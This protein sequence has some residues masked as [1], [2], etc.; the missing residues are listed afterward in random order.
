M[1][2]FIPGLF[3][4]PIH[5]LFGTYFVDQFRYLESKGKNY[6]TLPIHSEKTVKENA[7]F[8]K[9]F[10]K[11]KK[12]LTF[13]THSKG[14]I[15]LLDTLIHFPELRKNIKRIFFIQA[16][17]FGTPLVHLIEEKLALK[18]FT[19]STIYALRGSWK[20]LNEISP[21]YRIQYMNIHQDKIK[22]IVNTMDITCVGSMVDL[23][24][25]KIK[26]VLSPFIQY[27]DKVGAKG[28]GIVPFKS[29]QLPGA[30]NIQVN[31]I[32][33]STMVVK[34]TLQDFDRMEFTSYLFNENLEKETYEYQYQ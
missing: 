11:D 25:K 24:E 32:D 9:D 8:I 22:E 5:Y 30:K 1:V 31:G 26:S 19:K 3:S 15:D 7:L 23:E 27:L 12:D 33:H 20:A 17:F 34:R 29:T 14:G 21:E 10:I 13:V 4:G 16:P 28:D 6:E 18:W 2:Y